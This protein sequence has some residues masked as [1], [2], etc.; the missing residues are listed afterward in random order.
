VK[1]GFEIEWCVDCPSDGSSGCVPDQGKYVK[2]D[3][4]TQERAMAAALKRVKKDFFG[5]VRIRRF[6]TDRFGVREYA[7]KT[8]FVE[9]FFR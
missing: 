3:F 7:G 8:Q 1:E 5:A 2:E 4:A 6:S 9:R